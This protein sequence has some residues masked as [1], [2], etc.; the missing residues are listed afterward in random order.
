MSIRLTPKAVLAAL[1]A[2][3]LLLPFGAPLPGSCLRSIGVAGAAPAPS[4]SCSGDLRE[5]LRISADMHPTTFGVRYVTAED[6]ARCM[7]AF[8]SC[9][10]GGVSRGGNQSPPSSSTTNSGDNKVLPQHF[11]I[12]SE[13][14]K[15]TEC[16][17]NGQSVTC[18][19]SWSP[20]VPDAEW[21]STVTGT[22]S[23]LTMTGTQKGTSRS[24]PGCTSY[25]QHSGP[26]TYVFD[27]S[28]TVTMRTGPLEQNFTFSGCL[29]NEP[30]QNTAPLLEATGNWSPIE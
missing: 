15:L 8:R 26:V 19:Q 1:A 22:L 23:G 16:R 24:G 20:P 7:E 21:N 3:G 10:S 6:V 30:T 12:K 5:C 13:D 28:G 4:P 18:T 9:A 29:S 14:R 27:P 17:V 25:G 11:Q 2:V